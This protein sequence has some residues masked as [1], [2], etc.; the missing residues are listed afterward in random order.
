MCRVQG[1]AR[2]RVTWGWLGSEGAGNTE[3]ETACG[4]R[5]P[6]ALAAAGVGKDGFAQAATFLRQPSPGGHSGVWPGSRVSERG[7]PWWPFSRS[8][9]FS[10]LALPKAGCWIGLF[11]ES[12]MDNV[13]VFPFRAAPPA[14]SWVRAHLTITHS[15]FRLFS[16]SG[17]L[18]VA[19]CKQRPPSLCV[20]TR[21][22]EAPLH[23]VPPAGSLPAQLRTC[24]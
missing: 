22:S 10:W 2:A 23:P 18:L 11:R 24:L 1:G 21:P 8:L 13:D 19:S 6:V 14:T 9:F 15:R 7:R 5:L 17:P 16:G 4:G 12:T 3:P 20:H